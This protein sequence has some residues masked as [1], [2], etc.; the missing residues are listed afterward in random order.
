MD[1]I[2]VA[3]QL[4]G[5]LLFGVFLWVIFFNAVTSF[6]NRYF[7]FTEFFIFIYKKIRK[8]IGKPENHSS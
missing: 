1:V 8:L 4:A 5:A 3:I 7:R 6:I 2:L